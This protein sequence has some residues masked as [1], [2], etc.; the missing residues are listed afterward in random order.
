MTSL[1][2]AANVSTFVRWWFSPFRLVDTV[3][4]L[5]YWSKNAASFAGQTISKIKVWLERSFGLNFLLF[6]SEFRINKKK[7]QKVSWNSWML[8][9]KVAVRAVI[10]LSGPLSSLPNLI[11]DC[12]MGV[13][14]WN[15]QK[16]RMQ[17]NFCE[18]MGGKQKRAWYWDHRNTNADWEICWQQI[19]GERGRVLASVLRDSWPIDLDQRLCRRRKRIKSGRAGVE[20]L[21]CTR[22]AQ[23]RDCFVKVWDWTKIHECKMIL[24]RCKSTHFICCFCR[25]PFWV[26]LSQAKGFLRLL[27]EPVVITHRSRFAC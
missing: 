12:S 27:A 5:K 19:N 16:R 13:K 21:Y 10:L 2:T 6:E 8:H 26:L 25:C 15:K 22:K 3:T 4:P 14:M 20:V 17:L 7:A 9:E 23:A 18:L 1:K 11:A 24:Y